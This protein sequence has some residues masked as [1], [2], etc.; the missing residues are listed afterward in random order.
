MMPRMV[1]DS[2]VFKAGIP[3]ISKHGDHTFTVSEPLFWASINP[4]LHSGEARLPRK[5]GGALLG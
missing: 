5:L 1:R 2:C 4:V 3:L